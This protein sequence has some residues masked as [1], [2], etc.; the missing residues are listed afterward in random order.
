MI[1]K[2]RGGGVDHFWFLSSRNLVQSLIHKGFEAISQIQQK[3][4]NA[5][6]EALRLCGRLFSKNHG[7]RENGRGP[8]CFQIWADLENWC[9]SLMNFALAWIFVIFFCERFPALILSE[10]IGG[11]KILILLL[12]KHHQTL[13][14]MYLNSTWSPETK[15]IKMTNWNRRFWPKFFGA[16]APE[17]ILLGF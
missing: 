4:R 7:R 12:S 2:G 6:S 11:I 3:I 5:I 14:K 16:P 1:S 8:F 17:E 15:K 13:Q 9:R 10:L